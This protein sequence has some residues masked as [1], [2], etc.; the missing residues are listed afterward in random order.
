M[1]TAVFTGQLGGEKLAAA[2]ASLDLFV[3]PGEFETFGQTLQEA[4]ASGVPT[5]GPRAGGPIDTIQEGYNGLL[6]DVETFERDLPAAVA[7]ILAGENLATMSANARASI[8]DKTWPALCD[9]LLGYYNDVLDASPMHTGTDRF[10]RV[11]P[12]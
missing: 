10:P 5:I 1:P 4:Q 6:L 7:H 3:H 11:Q 2:Y 8:E 9:Q 12:V